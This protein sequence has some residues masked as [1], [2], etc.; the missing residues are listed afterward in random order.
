ML[1]GGGSCI[2]ILEWSSRPGVFEHGNESSPTN[3]GSFFF[4]VR[5]KVNL[6]H[7]TD[8]LVGFSVD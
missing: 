4:A 2:F 5:P 8:C 6:L 3:T 1:G 7:R